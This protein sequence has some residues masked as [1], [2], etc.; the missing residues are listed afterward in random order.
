MGLKLFKST[1]RRQRLRKRQ[2]PDPE[3]PP[4][5]LPPPYSAEGIN[6]SQETIRPTGRNGSNLSDE[7]LS[8]AST[9]V[10]EPSSRA[11]HNTAPP[12]Y[13]SVADQRRYGHA[14]STPAVPP[15][16][17]ARRERR[18]SQP[19]L[20]PD[21]PSSV[22]V[23]NF[24]SP[25]D[26]LISSIPLDIWSRIVEHCRPADAANLALANKTLRYRLGAGPWKA[27][28]RPGNRRDKTEVLLQWDELYPYQLLCFPC[29]AYHYRL[30][31][32]QERL[33]PPNAMITNP[34][35]DCPNATEMAPPRI[36]LTHGRMLNF[37]LLQL[38][39]RTERYTP[40][41]GIPANA[42]SR[43]WKDKDSGWSHT[44]R[45][46]FHN[47][48]LLFR[49]SSVCFA[50]ANLTP[51][52][53]R[54]LLYSRSDYAPYFSVCEHWHKGDLM[55]YAKCAVGHIPAPGQSIVEQLKKAPGVSLKKIHP[56]QFPKQCDE[57]KPIRRCPYCPTE[58]LI[59]IKLVEDPNDRIR[60]FKHAICVTRWSDFGECRSPWETEWA[61]CSGETRM[62]SFGAL[63]G[64]TLSTIFETAV[65]HSAPTPKVMPLKR[66][67]HVY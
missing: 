63:K 9:L 37:S 60:R 58:Y 65:S 39:A 62:N 34:V 24:S 7:R 21:E 20:F 29:G 31:P 16:P 27:L 57:C 6:P 42:L 13:G 8:I 50:D 12:R 61:S 5:P 44:T 19:P 67:G 2:Q 59:E 28:D 32:G 1:G 55:Q 49:A 25:G 26:R 47:N 45:I 15:V 54:L 46:Y 36:R 33:Q 4:L 56:D 64:A 23:P 10:I 51:S 66:G 18:A 17:R 40:T 14:P 41:H 52:Q 35:Y 48:H 30:R 43:R 53:Q 22:I 38:A 3:L 11:V